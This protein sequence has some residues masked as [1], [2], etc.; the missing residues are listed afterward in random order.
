MANYQERTLRTSAAT[1][2]ASEQDTAQT[3]PETVNEIWVV[4]TK[5]AEFNV[6]NLLTVRLQAQVSSVWFDVAWD[7]ITTTQVLSTAADLTSDVTRKTNIVD[8]D[9]TVP[10]YTIIAHYKAL[11]SDTVRIAS[12]SS[13]TS[14]A[15][16][17]GA[18]AY[19]MGQK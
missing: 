15:N 18:V 9:S 4:V 17:F 13:G 6:D 8:V 7:S 14:A 3:L 16:T 19:F 5:T 1:S 12:I 10:T 11:P 2:G